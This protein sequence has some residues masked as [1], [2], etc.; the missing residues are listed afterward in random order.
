MTRSEVRGRVRE[1][2][3]TELNDSGRGG[4]YGET[5]RVSRRQTAGGWIKGCCESARKACVCLPSVYIRNPLVN[6]RR[7]LHF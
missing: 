3:Y 2:I 4:G 5:W 7:G 1:D 6:I